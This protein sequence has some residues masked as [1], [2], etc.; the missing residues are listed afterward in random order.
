MTA[1]TRIGAAIGGTFLLLLAIMAVFRPE[2][3]S[4]QAMR[5][6]IVGFGL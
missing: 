1:R 3:M 2:M 4:M 5:N 6:L